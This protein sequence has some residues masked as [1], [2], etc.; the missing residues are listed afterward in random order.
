MNLDEYFAAARQFWQ[1]KGREPGAVTPGNQVVGA[2]LDAQN[3]L[4]GIP[5]EFL[6][7][8]IMLDLG[9]GE[10]RLSPFLANHCKWYI[11]CDVSP[12][13]LKRAGSLPL[14]NAEFKLLESL[15]ELTWSVDLMV[16]SQ[17]FMHVPASVLPALL[18]FL[19]RLVLPHGYLAFQLNGRDL[20][21]EHRY[22]AVPD[23]DLWLSR[24]YPREAFLPMI[25]QGWS[26]ERESFEPMGG[27][28]L[29]KI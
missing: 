6:D 3:L 16:A 24:W 2:E 26:V 21:P 4:A 19:C 13:C 29:Q 5:S 22:D 27:L 18:S 25:P 10:G 8:A 1:E 28:L 23:T 7:R 12:D 11:G 17:V 20:L 15:K 14:G 9:C